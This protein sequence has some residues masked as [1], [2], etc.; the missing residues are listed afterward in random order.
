MARSS[1]RTMVELKYVRFVEAIQLLELPIVPWWNWNDG[2]GTRPLDGTW[3][4]NRT[5]VELKFSEGQF[6]YPVLNFQSYHGGIEI[7]QGW[8]LNSQKRL[9]IVPWWNWNIENWDGFRIIDASN[10]TMVELK[11]QFKDVFGAI[12]GIF[13][14]YH[15]GIE[16]N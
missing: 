12:S 13:Q 5:M 6:L 9:P 11:C 7:S 1:N 2:T 3:A 10:R 14:S 16:I 8:Q 15:G 4:S